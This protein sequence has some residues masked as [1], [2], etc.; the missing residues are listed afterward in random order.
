MNQLKL[1]TLLSILIIS[2][3]QNALGAEGSDI[4]GDFMIS[5]AEELDI[6]AYYQ[7]L[8]LLAQKIKVY[9]RQY[10][11][12]YQAQ[13]SLKQIFQTTYQPFQLTPEARSYSATIKSIC[14]LE[15]L[16]MQEVNQ[17]LSACISNN[18]KKYA[19]VIDANLQ[20]ISQME[21]NIEDSVVT[22]L[23][24]T[25]LFIQNQILDL[26]YPLVSDHLKEAII[27]KNDSS[28]LNMDALVLKNFLKVFI[29]ILK[30][31]V[32]LAEMIYPDLRCEDS[33]FSEQFQ[34]INK[35]HRFIDHKDWEESL[36]SFL[37]PQEKADNILIIK[38]KVKEGALISDIFYMMPH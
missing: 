12:L 36:F 21:I 32:T 15:N 6:Q 24:Q 20:L 1:I 13:I 27:K 9:A 30:K 2:P 38:K 8:L 19:S 22:S 18:I 34:A 14:E 28:M 33:D 10:H 25:L 35:K 5:S 3:L 23:S 31:G 16:G 11:Y 26:Q 37:T 7:E 4:G 29:P 17:D